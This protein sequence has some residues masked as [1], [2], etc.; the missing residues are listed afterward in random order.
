MRSGVIRRSAM[1][2]GLWQ[3]AAW[4]L[5]SSSVTSFCNVSSA[6]SV[7]LRRVMLHRGCANQAYFER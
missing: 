5:L 3:A 4:I 7:A 1:L 2:P 6:A